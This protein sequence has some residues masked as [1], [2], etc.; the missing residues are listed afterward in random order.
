[1]DD[2]VSS[3]K[4]KGYTPKVRSDSNSD[5]QTYHVYLGNFKNK[6]DA[7]NYGNSLKEKNDSISDFLIREIPT[8]NP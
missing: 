8:D 2:F 4:A 6:D 1:M 5:G 7:A 3:L